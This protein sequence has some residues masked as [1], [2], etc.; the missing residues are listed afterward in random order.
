MSNLAEFPDLALTRQQTAEWIARLARGLTADER[1]QF[2]RWRRHPA[3]ARML[4]QMSALWEELDVM[5]ALAD[6]FPEPPGE[7]LAPGANAAS[8][9][10]TTA[11]S[12]SRA[13]RWRPALAASL[14]AAL[15]LGG[16]LLWQQ[17]PDTAGTVA[18]TASPAPTAIT[19]VVGEQRNLPLADGSGLALNTDSAV[20]VLTLEGASREL[21]LLRGEAHF[22][23]A[24]DPARP[25]RVAVGSRIVQA[26]GTAFNLRLDADGRFE[27]L[28]T[29]GRIALIAADGSRR[30]LERGQL[31]D[32]GAD[33]R[34]HES[35]LDATQLAARMSWRSG[36]LVF[37][38]DTLEAALAEFSRYTATRFVIADPALRTLRIG[39]YFPA[40]DTDVLLESLG[41]NLG[42]VARRG[43]DGEVRL[44]AGRKTTPGP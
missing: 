25:F 42:I 8:Q 26:V 30:P 21:R 6:V 20:E 19:T 28:V 41:S 29:D 9:A 37:D 3:N 35:R 32:I 33:G 22:T 1:E 12:P 38:G 13:R 34:L 39:G 23:V 15:L 17:R 10:T 2:Q 36:M 24:H 40:G 16:A 31:L 11:A 4:A 7:P 5:R 44:E 43:A 18:G 14:A 27:V